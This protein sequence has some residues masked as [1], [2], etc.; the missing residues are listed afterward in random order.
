[1]SIGNRHM[2]LVILQTRQAVIG[3]YANLNKNKI[4]FRFSKISNKEELPW[5]AMPLLRRNAVPIFEFTC[6][7]CGSSFEEIVRSTDQTIICPHCGCQ[8]CSR[9]PSA[10]SPLKKGA[11]PFKPGPVH[12]LGAYNRGPSPCSQCSPGSCPGNE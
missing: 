2:P 8:D 5:Q 4:G 9:Q 12:P 3:D 6:G 7:K 10:P 11:F 1:M